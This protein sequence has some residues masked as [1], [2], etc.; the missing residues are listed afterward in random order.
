MKNER[1]T[2]EER[3]KIERRVQIGLQLNNG[4]FRVVGVALLWSRV[5]SLSGAGLVDELGLA[6]WQVAG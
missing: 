6:A 5:V 1:I 4:R 3:E 2:S